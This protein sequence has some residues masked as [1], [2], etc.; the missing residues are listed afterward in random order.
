MWKCFTVQ[1]FDSSLLRCLND[2]NIYFVSISLTCC[3]FST[4]FS[5]LAERILKHYHYHMKKLRGIHVTIHW[6]TW[7]AS[8]WEQRLNDRATKPQSI[9]WK[10]GNLDG[11]YSSTDGTCSVEIKVSDERKMGRQDSPIYFWS[12]HEEKNLVRFLKNCAP[13]RGM[14]WYGLLDSCAAGT[15]S[16]RRTI[17][18]S[19]K[20]DLITWQRDNSEGRLCACQ[21]FEKDTLTRFTF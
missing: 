8:C 1:V 16:V 10:T 14:E 13:C 11:R 15:L 18:R 3:N 4:L 17:V 20:L 7:R 5:T 9:N 2:K 6:T 21:H 19:V 12:T